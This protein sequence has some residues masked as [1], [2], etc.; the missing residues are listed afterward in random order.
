MTR[1][2]ISAGYET[3]P[4]ISTYYGV[5]PEIT[6]SLPVAYPVLCQLPDRQPMFVPQPE[7]NP[8]TSRLSWGESFPSEK[9]LYCLLVDR[10]VLFRRHH[11]HATPVFT[12]TYCRRASIPAQM[13]AVRASCSIDTP[14]FANCKDIM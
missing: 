14:Y 3:R 7:H 8:L 12:L 9:P 1:L 6:S 4:K 2:L 5:S 13:L 11:N 10:L